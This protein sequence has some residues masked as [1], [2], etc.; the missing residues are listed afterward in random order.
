MISLKDARILFDVILN[1]LS[2]TL[3]E[4]HNPDR[5]LVPIFTQVQK[6]LGEEVKLEEGTSIKLTDFSSELQRITPY[7]LRFFQTYFEHVFLQPQE[8]DLQQQYWQSFG[9]SVEN[10]KPAIQATLMP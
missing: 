10:Q 8:L 2:N 5:I 1:C 3:N 9:K 7:S 6:D 4:N